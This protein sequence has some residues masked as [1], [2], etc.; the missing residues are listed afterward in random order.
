MK[1]CFRD[2]KMERRDMVV[3]HTIKHWSMSKVQDARCFEETTQLKTS[4]IVRALFES[5]QE[6]SDRNTLSEIE[7]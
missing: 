2:R 3:P 5:V 1:H 7:A 6:I 4:L